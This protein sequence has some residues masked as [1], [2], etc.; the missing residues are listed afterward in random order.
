MTNCTETPTLARSRK[1]SVFFTYDWPPVVK[2]EMYLRDFIWVYMGDH[3]KINS[4]HSLLEAN[5]I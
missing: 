5:L 1:S 4:Q 2:I 3:E